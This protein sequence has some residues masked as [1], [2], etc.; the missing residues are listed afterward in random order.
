MFQKSLR[1]KDRNFAGCQLFR[2]RKPC[3]RRLLPGDGTLDAAEM[4]NMR[5]TVQ[6]RFDVQNPKTLFHQSFGRLHIFLAHEDIENDPAVVG[7]DEGRVCHIVAAHLIDAVANL[8]QTCLRI[9]L[10]I[11]P[12]ARVDR[13]RCVAGDVAQAFQIPCGGAIFVPDDDTIRRFQQTPFRVR[14]FVPVREIQFPVPFRVLLRRSGRCFLHGSV[15][16]R[17]LQDVREKIRE[18]V[19]LTA[20]SVSGQRHT[21]GHERGGRRRDKIPASHFHVEFLRFYCHF[22][23]MVAG[24]QLERASQSGL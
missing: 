19:F 12:Q 9:E 24:C 4:V 10:G 1:G 2:N 17:I 22:T 14:K 6:H 5:V 20:S 13:V 18:T 15:G 23:R 16:I 11:P 8:E 3:I 7:V 21:A